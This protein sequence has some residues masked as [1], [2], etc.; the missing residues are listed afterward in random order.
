MQLLDLTVYSWAIALKSC[1]RLSSTQ[2]AAAATAM[3]TD[4]KLLTTCGIISSLFGF[5][6]A[7]AAEDERLCS[8]FN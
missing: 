8:H 2:A 4:T 7:A 3:V 1:R 6:G 5:S